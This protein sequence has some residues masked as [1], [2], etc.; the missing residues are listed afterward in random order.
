MCVC[1]TVEVCVSIS[2]MDDD[3]WWW[4]TTLS[5][6]QYIISL[7]DV[8]VRHGPPPDVHPN[9]VGSCKDHRQRVWCGPEVI[10]LLIL[11]LSKLPW[12][13]GW[14][15]QCVVTSYIMSIF[16]FY[17]CRLNRVWS[18]IGCEAS[19]RRRKKWVSEMDV[20]DRGEGRDMGGKRAEG[21]QEESDN[22]CLPWL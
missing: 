4:M 19:E 2:M 7:T 9:T 13:E 1:S 14:Q 6:Q 16:F 5:H 22:G 3:G 21:E 11:S 15:W 10:R 8:V 17:T 12:R 20:R 18:D